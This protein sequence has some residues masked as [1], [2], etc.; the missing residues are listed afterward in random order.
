[1]NINILIMNSIN[2]KKDKTGK[3]AKRQIDFRRTEKGLK[4]IRLESIRFKNLC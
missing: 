2:E 1:M 3:I 4:F